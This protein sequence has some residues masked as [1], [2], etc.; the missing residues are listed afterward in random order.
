MN[1]DRPFKRVKIVRRSIAESEQFVGNVI[2]GIREE[3]Q[4]KC[5]KAEKQVADVNCWPLF[6]RSCVG[7]GSVEVHCDFGLE[8]KA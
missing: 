4:V 6:C 8:S 1:T 2:Q 7:R 5:P 3:R